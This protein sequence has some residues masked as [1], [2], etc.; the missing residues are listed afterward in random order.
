MKRKRMLGVVVAL[1]VVLTASVSAA[2]SPVLYAGETKDYTVAF[3]AEGTQLYAIELAGKSDCYLTEPREDVGSGY[4]S[5]FAAPTLMR[6]DREGLIAADNSGQMA[7]VRAE[8]NS[9]AVRGDYFYNEIVEEGFHCDSGFPPESFQASRFEPVPG[10]G[11]PMGTQ[12][13]VYYGNEDSIEVFLRA[14]AK[15]AGGLRGTFVPT[16]CRVGAGRRIP[17]RHALFG[18]PTEVTKLTAGGVFEERVVERGRTRSGIP[19]KETSWLSGMVEEDAVTGSYERVRTVGP[20]RKA[21]QRCIT[22]PIPFRAARY[23]PAAG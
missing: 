2:A 21:K 3:K 10:S 16:S 20:R 9:D 7:L 18:E 19:Y 8:F 4:F 5:V 1:A 17:E 22:G 23:L 13:S 11:E 12:R 15:E 14:T 6:R